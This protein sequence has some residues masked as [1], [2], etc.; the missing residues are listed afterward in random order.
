MNIKDVTARALFVLLLMAPASYGSIIT[1]DVPDLGGGS[2]Q[3]NYVLANDTLDTAIV[4]FTI[5]FDVAQYT[6]LRSASGPVDWDLLA[7][8]PDLA[9]PD[10]GFFDGLRLGA[11]LG[12]GT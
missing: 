7:V 4:E 5:Y 12:A 2:G 6:K 3:Y 8:Q 11:P 1:Y 10:D 9:L